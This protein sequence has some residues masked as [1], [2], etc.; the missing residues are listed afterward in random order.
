MA[1]ILQV[2][3]TRLRRNEWDVPIRNFGC[4]VTGKM[5]RGAEPDERGYEALRRLG[6]ASVVCLLDGNVNDA[7]LSARAAGLRWY[8]LPL[9]EFDLPSFDRIQLWLEWARTETLLPIYVHCSDGRHRTAGLVAA[10]RIAVDN[11]TNARAYDEAR[12]FGFYPERGHG[13]WEYF[14]RNV[15]AHEMFGE[16]A[17]P[18]K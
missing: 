13:P 14:I 9:S 17:R 11:W 1:W 8:H 5:Y 7:G 16:P 2:L 12:H 6:V 4:V 15:G 3:K 18:T 10:Y